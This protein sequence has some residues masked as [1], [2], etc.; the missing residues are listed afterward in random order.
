MTNARMVELMQQLAPAEGYARSRLDDVTLMRADRPLPCM[1]ALYEPSIVFVV[2]GRKRGF[3]AGEM[4]VYDQQHYLVL[5][6]PLPFDIET[7]ASR[8]TPL[9]GISLRIDTAMTAQ[10]ALELGAGNAP[11]R[12]ATLF[13]SR[14]DA[15]LEDTLARL[16]EA[17]ALPDEARLLG[18]AIVRELTYRVLTGEQGDSLR[19]ALQHNSH[20]GRIARVLRRIHCDY[21]QPLDVATLAEQAHLSA[22]AFHVQFKAVTATS[23]LQYLKATRLHHARLL[24]VRQNL[25]AAGAA[26]Q[27]GYESPSQF[28]R[29]FR[30]LFGRP[31]G[32]EA[33]HLKGLL[34]LAAPAH[35]RP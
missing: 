21:A 6:V 29:E 26:A 27:V 17:L 30:R 34:S 19:A 23:P 18:P 16:L 32:E 4:Y 7:E 3:H 24:M 2:Q 25:S 5:S 28:S 15:R 11:G 13:S 12:P 35:G 8:E 20:F 1:P 31:P 9:L 10:L 33:L 22:P 14:M